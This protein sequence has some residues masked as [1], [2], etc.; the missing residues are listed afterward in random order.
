[1]AMEYPIGG[2]T[3]SIELN[4]TS[5]GDYTWGA[6]LYFVG[7]DM[8]TIKRMISNIMKTRAILEA[9]LGQKVVPSEE[10]S[11]YMKDLEIEAQKAA[12]AATKN[13]AQQ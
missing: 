6:K 13:D 2:G 11:K 12:E 5:K 1:M 10:M 4:R 7:N 8:R 3:S 9:M